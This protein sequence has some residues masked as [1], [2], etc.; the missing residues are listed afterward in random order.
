MYLYLGSL[1]GPGSNVL[2]TG[3]QSANSALVAVSS[4]CTMAPTNGIYSS[5]GNA[6]M[7]SCLLPSLPSLSSLSSTH[8]VFRHGEMLRAGIAYHD[9]SRQHAKQMQRTDVT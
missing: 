9:S 6:S 1:M 8:D 7:L 3:D 2:G 4:S 5:D